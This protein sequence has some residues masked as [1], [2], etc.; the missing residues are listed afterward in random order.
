MAS[1]VDICN[2]ALQKLGAKRIASLSDDSVNARACNAAYEMIRDAELRRHPWNFAISRAELPAD[3]TEPDWGRANAF[4][5]P[6][7]FL[8]LLPSYP[9]DNSLDTDWQIEG[10]KILTDDSAPLYLR[11]IARTADTSVYDPLFV[12][13][14]ACKIAFELCEE[15]TQSNA[16]KDGLRADYDDAIKQAKRTNAIENVAAQPPEDSWITVRG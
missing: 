10:Q 9:E 8:R 3:A 12:D 15:L 5:L 7:D 4:T 1:E 2:R 16:K 6:A 14:I 13:A 11:Y